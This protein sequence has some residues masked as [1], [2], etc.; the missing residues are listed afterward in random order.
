MCGCGGGRGEGG[1]VDRKGSMNDAQVPL[2]PLRYS[3]LE[4]FPHAPY[5]CFATAPQI[6]KI[7]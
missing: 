1:G 5:N 6:P 7:K 3:S 2:A 4:I